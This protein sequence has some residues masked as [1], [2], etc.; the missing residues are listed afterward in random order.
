[1]R[2]RYLWSVAQELYRC[3][4]C[5]SHARLDDLSVPEQLKYHNAAAQAWAAIQVG[6]E[7]PHRRAI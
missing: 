1:L 6:E 3:E 5:S 2:S 7:S 4:K